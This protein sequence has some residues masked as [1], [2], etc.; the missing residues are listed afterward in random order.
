MTDQRVLSGYIDVWWQAVNDFTAVLEQVPAEQWST[1]T[2]LAG[3]DV[4]AVAA[5]IAHLEAI[6]AGAPEETVEV[7]EPAHVTSL[8]G[9]YTEQ[10]V[11]ARRDR[12]PDDLINEIRSVTTARHTTLLADPPTDGTA[13]PATIFGGID[14]DWSRLLR[15]RPLDVWM[16]EQDVRRAVGLPGG[17]DTP[18]AQHTADYLMESLGV[19]LAKRVGAPAG[20]TAVLEVTGSAPAAVVVDENGRGQQMAELPA[21]P[22]VRLAMDREA[23]IVLAGGRRTPEAGAVTVEG[24]A[25]LG[26]AVLEKLAITP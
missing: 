1:P 8:M 20:T 9:L 16:H 2:D 21:D 25:A 15:N 23:W 10:G 24:D 11:V 26:K 5:H 12:S 14:W 3:W 18:A 4:Q 13:K 17:L 22:T 6:L 7:G 19:V